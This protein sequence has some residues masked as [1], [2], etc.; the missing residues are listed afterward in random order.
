M[1]KSKP[2]VPVAIIGLGA[3]MPDANNAKAFWH[4]ICS[5]KD[6]IREVPQNRWRLEDHY[7]PDPKAPDRTYSKIGAFVS[8][9][10]FNSLAFRIPPRVAASMDEV[11]KWAVVSSE[12]AI[13]D[14]GYDKKEFD[15]NR[16]AVIIGNAMAGE[17]QYFTNMRIYQPR[18]ARVLRETESFKALPEDIR[19]QILEEFHS[20][21]VENL[22]PI[23]EDSMPGE[24]S[25]IIAGRVANVFS[26]RGPN[27]TT[28]AACASS[29]A[30]LESA[31]TGLAEGRFDMVLTG[32]TDSSMSPHVFV[33]FCKVGALSAEKSCPFDKNAN[34]FVMGEGCGILL[35][36]RLDD[37]ERDG[38]NIYAV[39]RGLG[40]SSDGKGKG[41]TAPNPIGQQLAMQRAYENSGIS[42]A[43]VSL[44]EAHGTSTAA[45]DRVEGQLVSEFYSAAGAKKKSIA[46]GSIKS[47]IGHLKSAAGAAAL[48]KTVL[49]IH[50]KVIPGSLNFVTPNPEIPFDSSPVF[51][52]QK[53]H[54]W[55]VADG[56]PRVAALSAFGFGGTNF[57]VV[58]SEYHPDDR[59]KAFFVPETDQKKQKKSQQPIL[60]LGA[61][62]PASLKAALEAQI[63]NPENDPVEI[64]PD[65]LLATERIIIDY[66]GSDERSKRAKRAL[67]ILGNESP[68]AWQALTGQGIF[69]GSGPAKKVAFVFPGQG[70]QYV[71]MLKELR[72]H[73]PVVAEVFAEA[74]EIMTPIL[75][76]PLTDFIY[77]EDSPAAKEAL[78]D[79]NVCQPAMLA[80]DI[81]MARLFEQHGI[82]PDMVAGHSLGEYA[83]LVIAGML[84]FP[85]AMRAVSSR[86]REM[87]GV[88]VEDPGKMA[89]VLAPADKVHEILA[90]IDGVVPANMNSHNQTVIAGASQPFEVAMQR[91]NDAGIRAIQLQVSHAFHSFIVAPAMEP[92]RKMLGKFNFQPP[93]I[94]LVANLDAKL[95]DPDPRAMES[96]LDR[97]AKQIASPVRWVESLEQMYALGARIFVEVGVKRVL[98]NFTTDVLDDPEVVS[99]CSNHPKLGDF[100]SFNNALAALAAAGQPQPKP[101]D[102]QVDQI[103]SAE[104]PLEP[105]TPRTQP[106]ADVNSVEIV[107]SGTGLGLP[108]VNHPVFDENNV[109]NILAGQSCIDP[110]PE[111]ERQQLASQRIVRLIKDAPGGPTFEVIDDPD[112]VVQ[113]SGRKGEF[114]LAEEFGLDPKRVEAYD[115]TTQLAIG[116]GLCALRDAGIPLVMHHRNTTTGSKLPLGYHLPEQLADETGIIFASAFPGYDQL[117]QQ[118]NRRK[119]D[120]LIESRIE[121]LRLLAETVGPLHAVSRRIEELEKERGQRYNLDRKFLYR[122]LA[123][124]HTQ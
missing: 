53:T 78:R 27:Y 72:Q 63:E 1:N 81:A 7:D 50:E 42:P 123:F 76:K 71:N 106:T 10:E 70:S 116:A 51:V 26:L 115:I 17:M 52:P 112:Q 67:T 2:N 19:Q 85:E 36:K 77:T 105:S 22:P 12:Q 54:E 111:H 114:N 59:P 74:D 102:S 107:I 73:E 94:P 23:T 30:A 98:A 5:G 86:A 104:R 90:G 87:S 97:L 25:N 58:L 3:V 62:D 95:Y 113:L 118:M 69:R 24:L 16:T 35:L 121:E 29:L 38:D 75:G 108:G 11:Q 65:V 56:K 110:L 13:A 83:A 68:K 55:K 100:A 14:A 79:T 88:R 31:V 109:E 101:T 39:L 44:L 91:F 18:Y 119:R 37:A 99:V 96:N 8:D 80:G 64:K 84:S 47:Q 92:L 117:V 43:E 61:K 33:K 45:G 57:H 28:D 15:R 46:M 4:N 122:T 40:C 21:F 9:F 41:I 6:S 120:D 48:I 49:A 60:A 20:T 82:R 89:A 32:G 124:G 103:I 34:G 93:K 66:N